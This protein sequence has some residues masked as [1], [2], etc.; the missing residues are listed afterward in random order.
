MPS[1]L[2]TLPDVE[3]LLSWAAQMWVGQNPMRARMLR[4]Q[5]ATSIGEF[6]PLAEAALQDALR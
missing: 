3:T 4:E 5:Y 6:L 1:P 2:P